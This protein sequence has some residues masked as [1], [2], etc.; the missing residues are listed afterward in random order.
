[1]A[2]TIS[3]GTALRD[4]S[5]EERKTA[6]SV[7]GA[8]RTERKAETARENGR[9]GG[10]PKGTRNSPEANERIKQGRAAARQRLTSG[11]EG[12]AQ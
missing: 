11:D 3:T 4:G 2:E 10:R 7:M 6:A 8:A 9:R 1:M 5:E 12:G